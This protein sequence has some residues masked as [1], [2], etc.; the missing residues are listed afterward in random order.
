MRR[1]LNS[2]LLCALA[3]SSISAAIT[4]ETISYTI[5][6]QPYEGFL[7]YDDSS[8]ER[9]PGVLVV[10]EW[11]GLDD[12]TREKAREL[13]A[14]GYVAFAA[15]M[16]GK[17]RVTQD[18]QQ[19]GKWSAETREGKL[20]RPRARA[21]LEQLLTR[22]QV[23]PQRVAAI[24]FCYGGTTVLELAYSG[25][26]LDGVV[27]FHGGLVA[28]GESDQA[29]KAKVLILHG[30]DD[31]MVPP[32]QVRKTEQALDK[33]GVDWTTVWYSGA[34]HAFTNPASARRG[35]DAVNY[36]P[37]AARRAWRHMQLAFDEWFSSDHAGTEE[38]TRLRPEPQSK[39][40]AR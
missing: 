12:F 14:L 37:D 30:A 26:D 28:P 40:D 38:R 9:R 2:I 33:A 24:G 31:P 15:D 7:A 19:A 20:L 3:I 16:Y 25:A 6:G 4:T 5:D 1:M 32:D 34:R 21:A 23:D 17:G 27:S 18:P 39:G 11:W 22:P 36:Q 29:I 8:A 13:A 10:H 35:M